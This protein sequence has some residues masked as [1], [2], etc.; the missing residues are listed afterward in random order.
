MTAFERRMG[1][2]SRTIMVERLAFQ[3]NTARGREV[4]VRKL[5]RNGGKRI[6]DALIRKRYG[7]ALRECPF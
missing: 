6:G 2:P 3:G 4:I 7:P 1:E 5:L